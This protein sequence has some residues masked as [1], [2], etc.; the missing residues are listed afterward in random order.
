ML[1]IR[2]LAAAVFA[3]VATFTGSVGA[4]STPAPDAAAV[5]GCHNDRLDDLAGMQSRNLDRSRIFLVPLSMQG[6][7]MQRLGGSRVMLLSES[8]AQQL[9]GSPIHFQGAPHLVQVCF[10]SLSAAGGD[11]QQFERAFEAAV[12]DPVYYPDARI[13]VASTFGLASRT[14]QASPVAVIVAS[15]SPIDAVRLLASGAE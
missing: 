13:L 2:L 3:S 1:S 10:I 9:L 8:D 7:A 11:G 4:R 6:P 5:A 14:A 12:F 15:D